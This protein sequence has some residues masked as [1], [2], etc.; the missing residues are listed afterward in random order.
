MAMRLSRATLALVEPAVG[1]GG[2]D[3]RVLAADLVGGDGQGGVVA[4]EADDVQVGAR[5][6][7]HDHVG[8]L[9]LVEFELAQGLAALAGSIW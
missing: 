1:A 8:A 5:G 9:E 2:L 3:H 6:L 4:Q 7:D